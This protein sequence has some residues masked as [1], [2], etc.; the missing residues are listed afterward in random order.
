MFDC[1]FKTLQTS[2]DW[3]TDC[4]ECKANDS[5][6]ALLKCVFEITEDKTSLLP[7]AG[8]GDVMNNKERINWQALRRMIALND[9]L[10]ETG[11]KAANELQLCLDAVA[12][13]LR[14]EQEEAMIKKGLQHLISLAK[15]PCKWLLKARVSS[16]DVWLITEDT[17]A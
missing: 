7:W 14:E 17:I 15:G 13:G 5:E 2:V 4:R 16:E 10:V 12:A 9:Q 6:A 3:H 11:H 8:S 1:D